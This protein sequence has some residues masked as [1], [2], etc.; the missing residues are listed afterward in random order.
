MDVVEVRYSCFAAVTPW[1]PRLLTKCSVSMHNAVMPTS[2]TI[3]NV[4]DDVR[5][6]LA[7]RAARAGRSLQEHLRA[8]LIEL[9]R[10]PT[11]DELLE[12][13]RAR[14]ATTGS[15]LTAVDILRHRDRDRR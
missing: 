4:P 6:E 15:R 9:A 14:K 13:V 11:V 8:E 1:G 2:I 3:R 10:R 5:D 7:A 12:R